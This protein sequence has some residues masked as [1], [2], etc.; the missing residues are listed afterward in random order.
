[1]NSFETPE[2][3]EQ[4]KLQLIEDAK[5]GEGKKL[6]LAL[7]AL[8]E[9]PAAQLGNY[10]VIESDEHR[11]QLLNEFSEEVE[12]IR[13]LLDSLGCAYDLLKELRDRDGIMGYSFLVARDQATL[14]E[15]VEADTK[16][17]DK[18]FGIL[19]GYPKTA[20][21]AYQT[22]N[23]FDY[24]LELSKEEL[25]NLE[26]EGVLPF[27]EFMPS[28]QHWEEELASARRIRDVVKEK[29]PRLYEEL[30]RKSK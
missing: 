15:V 6:D 25:Q 2:K 29:I 24:S 9:K 10:D 20:I 4:E 17:D 3:T 1:M 13:T 19:M 23:A 21:D 5:L 18:T 8:G 30:E 16:G 11:E 7:L 28:K 12:T 14:S 27:L 22:E 26:S